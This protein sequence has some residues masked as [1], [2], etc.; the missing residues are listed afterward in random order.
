MSV[1]LK[2]TIP[3]NTILRDIKDGGSIPP[4]SSNFYEQTMTSSELRKTIREHVKHH[5]EKA[6]YKLQDNNPDSPNHFNS[7][8]ILPETGNKLCIDNIVNELMSDMTNKLTF[9]LKR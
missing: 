4:R 5:L 2:L 8:Y 9:Y 3:V 6:G 7:V 1:S